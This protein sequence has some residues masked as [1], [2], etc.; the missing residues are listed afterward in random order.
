VYQY[1]LAGKQRIA[2]LR[3]M[4]AEQPQKQEHTAKK[5]VY[6]Y[7]EQSIAVRNRNID[8]LKEAAQST[9]EQ[10]KPLPEY[11]RM[12]IVLTYAPRRMT[13]SARELGKWQCIEQHFPELINKIKMMK[14][15]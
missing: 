9:L 12:Q 8:A 13:T 4:I 6:C 2:E 11:E 10:L 3:R 15:A 7:M 5:I 14:R 1:T